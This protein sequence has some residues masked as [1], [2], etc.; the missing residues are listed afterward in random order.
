MMMRLRKIMGSAHGVSTDRGRLAACRRKGSAAPT[1]R[2]GPAVLLGACVALCPAAALGAAPQ[3][4][5][6]C[7]AAS[8]DTLQIAMR[9]LVL[10]WLPGHVTRHQ[11]VAFAT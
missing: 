6:P 5:T 11:P 10:S 3:D 1:A 9:N 8:G 2:R 7:V 4:E